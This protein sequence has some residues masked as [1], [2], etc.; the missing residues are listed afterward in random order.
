MKSLSEYKIKAKTFNKVVDML[1][2]YPIFEYDKENAKQYFVDF[3]NEFNSFLKYFLFKTKDNFDFSNLD[4]KLSSLKIK[5]LSGFQAILFGLGGYYDIDAHEIK[6][7]YPIE[8]TIY[9]ELFHAFS[10]FKIN[11]NIYG[12]GFS[13][14]TKGINFG[15]MFDEGYTDHL[16]FRYFNNP[17]YYGKEANIAQKVEHVIGREE[18]E[19]MYSKNNLVSL[20]K[21]LSTFSSYD[22]T[23]KFI[24]LMER[25]S[26]HK[27]ITYEELGI[28]N[29]ISNYLVDLYVNY[30][31]TLYK[32][33]FINK[34]E[35]ID[36]LDEF[37]KNFSLYMFENELETLYYEKSSDYVDITYKLTLRHFMN[38]V[39]K[40]E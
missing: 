24:M 18:M 29:D 2:G 40:G 19:K 17:V 21:H 38:I 39:D 13:Y 12:S 9:H 16:T 26:V 25:L 10:S 35:I 36:R 23:V 8:K 11:N 31:S 7:A 33:G 20:L 22:E 3:K 32:D 28:L 4:T 14:H 27:T 15:Y 5:E 1:S 34:D 6:V 37:R 30:L